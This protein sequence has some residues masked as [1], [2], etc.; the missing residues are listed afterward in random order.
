MQE[1]AI[2]KLKI[3]ITGRLTHFN[4]ANWA[5]AVI[6]RRVAAFS[7]NRMKFELVAA[8]AVLGVALS[9]CAT[10]VKGTTQSISVATPP[11]TGAT[12]TLTSSEGTWYITTP[13][14]VTVHQNK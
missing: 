3:L 10:L 9:G 6:P 4:H 7:G 2:G 14:S 13:G 5:D 8:V 11:V 12:C 1:C